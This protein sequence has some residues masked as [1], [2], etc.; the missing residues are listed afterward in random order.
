VLGTYLLWFLLYAAFWNPYWRELRD[1]GMYTHD[2]EGVY[3]I[4][5]GPPIVGVFSYW[6][7]LSL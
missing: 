2:I 5:F 3:L 7:R 6:R 4:T 1:L